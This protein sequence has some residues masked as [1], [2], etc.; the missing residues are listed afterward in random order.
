MLLWESKATQAGDESQADEAIYRGAASYSQA[1]V[2]TRN[3]NYP[4][5]HWRD[6]TA[7]HEILGIHG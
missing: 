4:N 7:G 1:L 5:I 6:N 2:L 3:F